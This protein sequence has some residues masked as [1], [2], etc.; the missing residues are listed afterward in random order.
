MKIPYI[1]QSNY[2]K[3]LDFEAGY[4]YSISKS[5]KFP[6]IAQVEDLKKVGSGFGFKT[7]EISLNSAIKIL[8]KIGFLKRPIFIR[9]QNQ[10]NFLI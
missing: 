1:A 10:L 3:K 9:F 2:C 7:N 6:F 5:I 8:Q 4:F